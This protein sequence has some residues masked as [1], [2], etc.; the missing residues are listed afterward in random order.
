MRKLRHVPEPR[1]LVEVTTRTLQGMLLLRPG[2]L[3]NDIILGVLG[4]AQRLYEVEIHAYCFLATH[5]HLLLTVED[6]GQLSAFMPFFNTN[7]AREVARLTGW[8][9]KIW[10]RRYQ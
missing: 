3:L 9:E 5:S 7:H 10:S 2:T 8:N 1:T 6:A 4:R